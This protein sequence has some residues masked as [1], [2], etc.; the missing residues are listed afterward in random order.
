MVGLV[1]EIIPPKSVTSEQ[2]ARLHALSHRLNFTMT[3]HLRDVILNSVESF[4]KLWKEYDI[5]D[6]PGVTEVDAFEVAD[7][8]SQTEIK[9]Q[10]F[11][12][13]PFFLI[14]LAVNELNEFIFLPF[15]EEIEETIMTMLDDICESV[16]GIDDLVSRLHPRICG[17]EVSKPIQT[18]GNDYPKVV[19]ARIEIKVHA[20]M[21]ATVSTVVQE[22]IQDDLES[23]N[24]FVRGKSH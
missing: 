7:H 17:L 21:E 12:R 9:E 16:T 4:K 24:T 13:P 1:E 23:M 18:I 10:N 14:K 19:A 2:K 22:E 6:P 3:Q 8:N 15:L 5:Q 20:F 11:A